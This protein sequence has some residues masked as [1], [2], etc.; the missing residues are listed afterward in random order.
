MTAVV[1][2]AIAT[3]L[4]TSWSMAQEVQDEAT[5]LIAENPAAA[6]TPAGVA[7]TPSPV[8]DAG[9]GCGSGCENWCDYEPRWTATADA[10]FLDRI[11]HSS[12][13]MVRRV[14]DNAVLGT[15]NDFDFNFEAG[16]RLSLIRHG[17]CGWDLEATYFGVDGW[18]SA[19][20]RSD[21][22]GVR[23]SAPDVV[24][25]VAGESPGMVFDYRSRLYSTEFNLR[26]SCEDSWLT[27]LIGFR[28]IELHENL[29][30]QP[31]DPIAGAF[32]NT[33]ADNFLY[34]FQIGADMKVLDRGG[35]FHIDGLA[36]AGLYYNRAEQTS[37][38]PLIVGDVASASDDH[39]AFAAELGLM[40]VYQWTERVA[41]RAGY[42]LMWLDGVALAP[43]QIPVSSAPT[44]TAAVDAGGTVF[45]HGATAGLEIRF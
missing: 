9:Y 41:L 31:M 15:A 6:P 7:T 36:K 28:Y 34:G 38:I 27:P 18:N 39:T 30:G 20:L 8:G 2:A 19:L 24:V 5:Y 44:R 14:S 37:A 21:V 10:L 43:N 3:L 11:S 45:Y 29:V 12:V 17:D 4:L 32:W 23:F 1:R 40:G 26:R 16:P 42:Q 25:T 35:K 22:S 13:V 33:D